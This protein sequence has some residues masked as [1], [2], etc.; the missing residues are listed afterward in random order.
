MEPS[1]S[2][3]VRRLALEE[4]RRAYDIQN[5]ANDLI[6][7]KAAGVLGNASMILGLFGLLQLTLLRDGQPALYQAGLLV[8][9][10]LYATLIVLVAAT[11][12]PNTF[13]TP[14][15]ADW[16]VVWQSVLGQADNDADLSM[17]S[18]YIDTV[19]ALRA[20]NAR[21]SVYA[22]AAHIMLPAI[23]V[24]ILLLGVLPR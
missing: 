22:R 23:V 1:T 10:G 2:P 5:S 17:I 9:L 20:I 6:D 19:Q 12:Y 7:Q 18:G 11:L 4:L 15:K 21:K 13:K 24:G 14:I 16:D 8:I 3:E